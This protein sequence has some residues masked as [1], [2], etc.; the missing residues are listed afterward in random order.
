MEWV[1]SRIISN[2][3]DNK[4]EQW[5]YRDSRI[6]KIFK[7][8]VNYGKPINILSLKKKT[9][10]EFSCEIENIRNTRNTMYNNSE[11]ELIDQCPICN[12]KIDNM[13]KV[14]DVY[15]AQYYQCNNCSHCFIINRPNKKSLDKF[16]SYNKK[17]QSVYTDKSKLKVRVNEVAHPK[18][19]YV[20]NQYENK[21]GKKPTSILDIGAGSGHFVYA[22]RQLGIKADGIE[23]S[24]SGRQFWN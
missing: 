2:S 23:I 7:V 11:L 16:Y 8:E 5:I 22:C 19:E 9:I 12:E 24:E 13:V 6:E 20:I 1:R 17:Y 15:G 21:Y 3:K 18:A 14:F 10:S 4:N